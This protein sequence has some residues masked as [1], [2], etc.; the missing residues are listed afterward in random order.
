MSQSIHL[1]MQIAA[2]TTKN[3]SKMHYL[4]FP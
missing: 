2:K 1:W 3:N 4:L